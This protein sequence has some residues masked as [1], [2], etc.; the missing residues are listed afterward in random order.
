MTKLVSPFGYIPKLGTPITPPK[1]IKPEDISIVIPVKNNQ[2]GIDR[3]LNRLEE[4]TPVES[5]PKEVII[6]DNNSDSPLEVQDTYSFPVSVLR[7]SRIGPAAARNDGMRQ[8]TG[9]WILFNDSD[10][11]PTKSTISGYETD[12]NEFLAYAGG[13]DVVGN[14]SLSNYYRSQKIL[15]PM[16]SMHD[17]GIFPDYLVT[18]NALVAKNAAEKVGGFDESFK[19]AGG[20][21]IDLAYKLQQRG[22]ISYQEKSVTQHEFDD[23]FEGFL[24]RFIRYGKGNK[25]IADK[26][27]VD[28][29]P[30]FFH[31]E[32][33]GPINY[34]LM[35]TQVLSMR[36]GFE[37]MRASIS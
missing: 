3:Y 20:E 9:D 28:I 34:L 12:D 31:P 1:S 19:Q 33:V 17:D 29:Y 27:K 6:V 2:S 25:Q 21:D 5:L 14:D 15:V 26:Y 11:I 22:G 35:I 8:A 24:K 23:G 37:N 18:A 32:K 30:N 16:P 10:C 4:V 36:K 7:C 13:I